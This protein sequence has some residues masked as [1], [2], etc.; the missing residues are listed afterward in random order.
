M[1]F[2]SLHILILEE[3][4]FYKLP[5]DI[6]LKKK[7]LKTVLSSD[8]SEGTATIYLLKTRKIT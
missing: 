5:M 1:T 2:A 7:L 6:D 4:C 8:A 3:S